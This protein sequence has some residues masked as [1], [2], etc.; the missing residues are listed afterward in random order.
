M[1]P[2]PTLEREG[3]GK[4]R[5]GVRLPRQPRSLAVVFF[6]T[7]EQ[8]VEAVAVAIIILAG[9]GY[10]TYT[11]VKESLEGVRTASLR[12]VLESKVAAL[13][14]WA[15]TKRVEAERWAGDP[16]VVDPVRR[17]HAAARAGATRE[18]LWASPERE[19][20][21]KAL[22]PF[23]AD[24]ENVAAN[25]V[26]REGRIL[27]TR[28]EEYGGR[29]VGAST[30]ADLAPVFRG[31]G[32]LISPRPEAER[33][34][35]ARAH[36]F[37]RPI[38]WFAAPVRDA[39]GQVIAALELGTYADTR[40][41]GILGFSGLVDASATADAYAFDDSG[42]LL[43]EPRHAAAL[44]GA[45]VLPEGA[46]G[47]A[48]GVKLRD[49]GRD[50][51]QGEPRPDDLDERPLTMVVERAIRSRS[52]ADPRSR[53]GVLLEP[54][55][56]YVGRDVISAWQWLPAYDIGV[57]VEVDTE[58]AYAPLR[59]L[60]I[61]V[62][63]I[64]AMLVLAV[65]VA[66]ASTFSV[67]SMRRET[68]QLGQ[69]RLEAQIAEGGQATVH[70]AFH[71]LLRR[72]TAVKILKRH[73]ATDE[74]VARF[75]RE[76]QLASSLVH[77]ATVEIFDYGRTRDGTFFYV[78]EYID[79]ITLAELLEKDG[80]QPVP[81]VAH[82]LKQVCESLREAHGKGFVHRDIK[83]GNVMLCERGG[84]AD[85]VKVL[86]FGLIKDIYATDTRDIT[87]Y[88]TVLGT[89]LFMAPE[90]LRDPADADARADIYAVGAVA[91]LLLTGKR[92]FEAPNDLELKRQ[93][94]EV[95]APRVTQ[96]TDR[97]VPKA[98]D[99]LVARCLAKDRADRP[100]HVDELIAVCAQLLREHPWTQDAAAR[101][102]QDFYAGREAAAT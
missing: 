6:G 3:A 33:V 54:H 81:R 101:W 52:D 26:D 10:W 85:V 46:R 15:G 53:H 20:V 39:D 100:Q 30:L 93:I 48:F 37:P 4:K 79:G 12:T 18:A 43:T 14:V 32:R 91:F 99:D 70:R 42:L 2:D 77:P 57:A 71:A 73:L 23:F 75:E 94:L 24:R 25:V 66:L 72:P 38:V 31:Q 63:I 83:P 90:R 95:E 41:A 28:V 82:I 102:W 69:Y 16:A 19:R 80:P 11:G 9:L 58:E 67:A 92:V 98:L 44:R 61:A 45:G 60:T 34:P 56:N 97:P 62:Q 89:P 74:L 86:D 76:V 1:I 8:R 68:R 22:A 50:L 65:A 40:F 13:D 7:T 29:R 87:Q 27:A 5:G 47:A 96:A 35:R 64:F 59:Y 51:T 84:V 88:A 21:V 49:P 78:M 55:R 17:L 36:E